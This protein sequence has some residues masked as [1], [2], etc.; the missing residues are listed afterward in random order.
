MSR[1]LARTTLPEGIP[2]D[3]VPLETIDFAHLLAKEPAEIAKLIKASE[4]LGFFYL[5]LQ[6]EASQQILAATQGVYRVIEEYFC[7][8]QELKLKD[9]KASQAHG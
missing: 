3:V 6:S 5:N 2:V 8:P 7:Q 1:P 9:Y 4:T